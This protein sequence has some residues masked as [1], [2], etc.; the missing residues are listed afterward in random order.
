MATPT[1]VIRVPRPE[2]GAFNPHRPLKKNALLLHQVR[3]FKKIERRLPK[4]QKTG[5]PLGAIRTEAQ[6]A[7]YL[8]KMMAVLHPQTAAAGRSEPLP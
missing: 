7:E 5:I 6:A 8:R 2:P 4:H 3:H 1:H